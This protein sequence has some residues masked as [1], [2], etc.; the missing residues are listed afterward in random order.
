MEWKELP[1]WVS[2]LAAVVSA[3]GV[4]LAFWQ[5]KLMKRVADMQFEDNLAREYRELAGR[6]P[7]KAML[8]DKLEP[9]EYQ[10]ALEQLIH[11]IDLSNEQV[12]L[13]QCGRIST[14]TWVSWRDGIQS[15]LSLADLTLSSGRFSLAFRVA[16]ARMYSSVERI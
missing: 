11:Y 9:D 2:A 13:R 3:C 5:L 12:F 8:G 16:W 6:M 4:F 1:A 14:P 15:N 7:T 10:K